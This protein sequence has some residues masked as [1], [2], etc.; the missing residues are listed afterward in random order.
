[1]CT[2]ALYFGKVIPR[3]WLFK[4]PLPSMFAHSLPRDTP[5]DYDGWRDRRASEAVLEGAVA[6]IKFELLPSSFNFC[7]SVVAVI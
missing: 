1:M 6:Q 3:N 5:E 2:F 4:M 7:P